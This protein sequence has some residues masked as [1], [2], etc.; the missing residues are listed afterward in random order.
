[1]NAAGPSQSCAQ[2][3][4]VEYMTLK[5]FSPCR[6]SMFSSLSESSA[7]QPTSDARWEC[8]ERVW[9]TCCSPVNLFPCR[10]PFNTMFLESPSH[11]MPTSPRVPLH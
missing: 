4:R 6:S 8:W 5:S 7:M 2:F 9:L 10:L 1:M 11:F 3:L